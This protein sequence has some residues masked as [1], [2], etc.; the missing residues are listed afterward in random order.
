MSVSAIGNSV[1]ANAAANQKSSGSDSTDA[2]TAYETFL[3]LLVTQLQH[4]DPLNPTDSTQFTSQ[5]IQLSNVEQQEQ[6]NAQLASISSALSMV[7]L[8]TGVAYLDKTVVYSGDTSPLQD[9]KA[10]WS[11]SLDSAADTVKLTVTDAD[12]NVVYSAD[13]ETGAG[14]HTFSWDGK[15]ADG[16]QLDSGNYKLTVTAT[17][18]AGNA[19][20]STI[21]GTGKVTGID[22][23]TGVPILLLG[24]AAV[25]LAAVIGVKS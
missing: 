10:S 20:D 6:T 23:S 14:G 3:N 24:N 8:S 4:Q 11:Y 17:D 7:G 15:D 16:N 2:T 1:T 18:N 9:G 5:L 22:S 12:G 21:Y 19:V 25:E 13:G